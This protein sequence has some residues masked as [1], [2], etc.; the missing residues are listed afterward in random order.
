MSVYSEAADRVPGLAEYLD[1]PFDVEASNMLDTGW[2]RAR[3]ED[4]GARWGCSDARVNGTLWWYSASSTLSFLAVATAMVTGEAADPALDGAR[5][6]LRPNGYLGGILSESTIAVPE[7]PAALDQVFA[8]VI[9]ALSEASGARVRALWAIASDS[10]ANR[11]LDVGAALGDR[12]RGSSFAEELVADMT[13]PLPAPRFVDVG[14]RRF[15]RR[16]SCCLLYVT[17]GAD[18]CTSC[19]RRTPSERLHGLEVAARY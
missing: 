19:P 1:G 15:T 8:G 13:S 10:I 3:V 12:L 7:L 11:C 2:L 9:E 4:T 6:F 16:C 5:C 14:G 18:K 17:E